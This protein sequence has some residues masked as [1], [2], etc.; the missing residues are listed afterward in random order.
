MTIRFEE[1]GERLRAFRLGS[2]LSADEIASR[3]GISRTALYRFEKGRVAKIETLEK[4]AELLEVSLPTLLGVGVEYIGSAVSFFERLRQIEAAA[5]HIVVLA[6]PVS[7]LLSSDAFV[8][9]LEEVLGES[10]PEGADG[11]ARGLD[12]VREL[13]V[14]LRRRKET[15]RERRPGVLNL[16]SEAE[17]GRFLRNGLVGRLDLPSAVRKD[18]LVRA[19]KEAEHLVRLMEDEPIGVQI[20]LVPATLPPTSFQIFRQPGRRVLTLSPFRLGEQPN[21]HAGVAMITSAPEALA[22][23]EKTAADLWRRARKGAV[24]ATA[25]R[26]LIARHA[27][28]G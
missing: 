11:R 15:Y 6:G 1:I 19:R 10:I 23:H 20:G 16:I 28:T 8:D 21:I 22:L 25:M 26:D 18:R 2:G 3:I 5:E 13:M 17:M 12:Q 14:I 7:F 27:D 24:A 9:T 4:L